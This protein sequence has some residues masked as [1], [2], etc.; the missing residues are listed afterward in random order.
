LVA[1]LP[2]T[3]ET[4]DAPADLEDLADRVQHMLKNSENAFPHYDLLSE[5]TRADLLIDSRDLKGLVPVEHFGA[6]RQVVRQKLLNSFQPQI[7]RGYLTALAVPGRVVHDH[8]PR[9]WRALLKSKDVMLDDGEQARMD[10]AAGR[11]AVFAALRAFVRLV[12]S[13]FMSRV[14]D[15]PYAILVNLPATALPSNIP[16]RD[17]TLVPWLR[18]SSVLPDPS[19]PI[20]VTAPRRENFETWNLFSSRYELPPLTGIWSKAAFIASALAILVRSGIRAVSGKW[21]APLLAPAA[22]ELAYVRR[23][24]PADR[25]A[26]CLFNNSNAIVRPLWTYEI[27]RSG[28]SAG[29]LFYSANSIPFV[30]DKPY[31][32]SVGS[33]R[34][35]SWTRYYAWDVEQLR[36]LAELRVP[37]ERVSIVGP[38]DFEDSGGALPDDLASHVAIFDVI[39]HKR[40]RLFQKGIPQLFYTEE[41][42]AKFATDTVEAVTA[43]SLIP[44]FKSKRR[45]HPDHHPEYRPHV[46]RLLAQNGLFLDEGIAARRMIGEVRAVISMPFTSTAVIAKTMGKPSAFYDP[47]GNL[48]FHEDAAHG[49]PVLRNRDELKKWISRVAADASSLH[50]GAAERAHGQ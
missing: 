36:W 28:G 41:N 34:A 11:V 14:P 1:P 15:R 49:L 29:L 46:S 20:L 18:R 47:T 50:T 21:W 22:L 31:Y 44:C 39:P 12:I 17:A 9:P 37:E 25:T 13:S 43:A 23:T 6:A 33:W 35:M 24:R 40:V 16:G 32:P 5:L 3:P 10:R 7:C 38:V 27:E 26:L 19:M 45:A 42:C 48:R 8:I 2:M 4:K 30:P